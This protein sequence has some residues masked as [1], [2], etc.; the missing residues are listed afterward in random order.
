MLII[1]HMLMISLENVSQ[2]AQEINMLTHI[3]EHV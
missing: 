1:I 2:N 3:Y